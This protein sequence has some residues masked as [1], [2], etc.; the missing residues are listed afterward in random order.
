MLLRDSWKVFWFVF[1]FVCWLRIFGFVLLFVLVLVFSEFWEVCFGICGVLG[2]KELN[3]FLCLRWVW[4]NCWSLLFW[5]GDWVWLVCLVGLFLLLLVWL[6]CLDVSFVCL[7]MG[8]FFVVREKFG[9]LLW[10]FGWLWLSVFWLDWLDFV[11]VVEELFCGCSLCGLGGIWRFWSVLWMDFWICLGSEVKVCVVVLLFEIWGLF[12]DVLVGKFCWLWVVFWLS[13]F[14]L[15]VVVVCWLLFW[16]EVKLLFGFLGV[17]GSKEVFLLINV[18][19]CCGRLLVIF[20][21]LLKVKGLFWVVGDK[22]VILVIQFVV[23]MVVRK[24][25]VFY[26]GICCGVIFLIF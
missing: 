1:R 6:F 5:V 24:S 20:C 19:I 9:C 3:V 12:L 8:W 26:K 22:R 21:M 17:V 4:F 18:L 2:L 7:F 16:F 11:E 25:M 14:L 13:W 15:F 23:S 10:V